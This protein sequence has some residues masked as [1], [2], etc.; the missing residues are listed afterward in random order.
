MKTP[1]R[2]YARALISF[3]FGL[4]GCTTLLGIPDPDE[5][6]PI[7]GTGSA[8]SSG[9]GG[10]GGTAA[11]TSTSGGIGGSVVEVQTHTSPDGFGVNSHLV[12]G[13]TEAVLIDGQFFSAEAQKVVDLIKATNKTLTTVFLTHAHADH[14]IGMEVIRSAFPNA[15]FVTTASVLVD[16]DAKKDTTLASLQASFPGQVPDQVVTFTAL[17]GTSIMVDEYPLELVEITTPGESGVAAS[18]ALKSMKWFIAGDLLYNQQHLWLAECNLVGWLA[19]LDTLAGMGFESFYPGHGPQGGAI[20]IN[21]DK[22]Y[23]QDALPILDAALN[24][25]EAIAYLNA[26]YPNW[27]GQA[28]LHFGVQIHFENCKP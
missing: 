28:S 4:A 26:A 5:L 3:T 22:K 27:G 21:E 12:V 2:R 1:T 24:P 25:E 17:E 13:P 11:S 8:T 9:I 14:Y 20:M 15:K 18:L 7:S 23:L 10:S 16:Y 19:N 6:E